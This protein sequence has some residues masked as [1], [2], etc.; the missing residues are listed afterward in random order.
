MIAASFILIALLAIA[1]IWAFAVSIAHAAEGFEDEAGFHFA[2]T[3]TVRR[4][5]RVLPRSRRFSS[6]VGAVDLHQP[7]A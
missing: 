3:A 7:V 1:S 4:R 2:P 6:S 5:A